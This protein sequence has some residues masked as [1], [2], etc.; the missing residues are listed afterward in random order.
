MTRIIGP[1]RS[2]RRRRTFFAILA[3]ALG[4]GVFVIAGAQ[5]VHDTG[6]FQLDGNA[7]TS[8]LGSP[9]ST[10]AD[11]WDRVCHQVVGSDCSTTSNTTGAT[12][13][14]FTNDGAQNGTIFTTGGSKD[15]NDISQW[16]WKD[17]L[18]GL[19]DKDN[20]QD[21]FAARYSLPVSATCPSLAPTCELLYFGSDRVD[22]SGDAQE[23]FWLLQ[24]RIGLD[25]ASGTFTSDSA[26]EFHKVGDILVLTDFSVG[27][28]TSTINV[29]EWV[30]S[31]GDTNGTLQSLGGGTNR[32]C[33]VAAVDNFCGIVNAAN[34]TFAPWPFTDKSGFNT[35]L[36]GELF[37][38]GLNLGQLS[39][40]IASECFASFLSETRSSTS[41][42]AT[43]KDFVL[44]NFGN[45]TAD[46]TTAPSKTATVPG[47]PVHDIATVTGNNATKT[48]SG[49]VTFFLCSFAA[50]STATCDGTTNV[51]TQIGTGT[52][53]GSGA[54]ATANSPD[55]NTAASPLAPGHYCFRA[56]WPGDSNYKGA[57]EADGAVE[58]FDISKINSSTLT[59]PVDG[60]GTATSSITLGSS[61]FDKAVVTGTSAG[62]DPTGQVNF[63]V[64]GPIASGTCDGT[65]NVGSAVPGNPKTLVSDGN[66]ATF[67][68]SATSGAFTPTAVGRYCFRAEYGGSTTY[69]ASSD[70]A[71]TE[72][73]TVNDTTSATS[74]QTWLP[75]D[76]AT[77]TSAH[78]APING[79]LSFTLH[80]GGTCTGTVL[81]SAETFT[82]TNETSPV[83]KSTTNGTN[84]TVSV[85]SSQTVSWEVVFTSSD[86]N[87][88]GSTKCETTTLTIT[89]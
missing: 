7:Q 75:N 82:L 43:L 26:P 67:T 16:Q 61:I 38:G 4:V 87:V 48:P 2:R 59:T 17:Q 72:C 57:K 88:S 1:P 86:A 29:Y 77:I 65:T 41:P 51:G 60:S 73:F 12:A 45:C 14:S 11:D 42:T 35:Y 58:C 54:T 89:N 46:L 37:E 36:Q 76:S 44:G 34:G 10:G 70:S 18:G 47:D 78:G 52:L 84:N 9:P 8:D 5:A 74:A 23:G 71:A 39:A 32:T 19:P 55:V 63:F 30:G 24:N 49:T 80:A 81:R 79:T 27:G 68:S 25:A 20:L 40:S 15:P 53:T 21:S 83:T 3:L 50:G 13:V 69:N 31:G 56:T 6:A 64:C 85:T 28:S 66:P 22:N 33:G 62:G